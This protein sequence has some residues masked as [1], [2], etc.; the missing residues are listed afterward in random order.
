MDYLIENEDIENRLSIFNLLQKSKEQGG[1]GALQALEEFAL[2]KLFP[3]T[4]DYNIINYVNEASVLERELII[5][6]SLDAQ[7]V[8]KISYIMQRLVSICS[9]LPNGRVILTSILG[10]I[11]ERRTM[12]DDRMRY[13]V[14]KNNLKLSND[15]NASY[16]HPAIAAFLALNKLR[17]ITN[18]F[19]AV[20]AVFRCSDVI[21]KNNYCTH[22]D[23][24]KYTHI[25]TEYRPMAYPLLNK[26]GVTLKGKVTEEVLILVLAQV[27][28]ALEIAHSM[29]GYEH[30]PLELKDISY[31]DYEQNK[32]SVY[33]GNN[34]KIDSRYGAFISTINTNMEVSILNAGFLNPSTI[35]IGKES[36]VLQKRHTLRV[37]INSIPISDFG[38]EIQKRFRNIEQWNNPYEM[39]VITMHNFLSEQ[40]Y[41]LTKY[42][43]EKFEPRDLN[44]A[45][46]Q[47]LK[48]GIMEYLLLATYIESLNRS[49]IYNKIPLPKYHED[50]DKVKNIIHLLSLSLPLTLNEGN[51]ASTHL[52]YIAL[53]RALEFNAL[54]NNRKYVKDDSTALLVQS[55]LISSL[56]PVNKASKV[57]VITETKKIIT[58]FQRYTNYINMLKDIFDRDYWNIEENR[59]VKKDLTRALVPI[60]RNYQNDFD[61]GLIMTKFKFLKVYENLIKNFN[62][63]NKRDRAAQLVSAYE[64][65]SKVIDYINNIVNDINEENNI[66]NDINDENNTDENLK[67][68]IRAILD[69]SDKER[70]ANS[71]I[72]DI[73]EL[74]NMSKDMLNTKNKKEK[75]SKIYE[76]I[77]AE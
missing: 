36:I 64:A 53:N 3:S 55:R 41:V 74:I 68:L 5:N 23:N 49:I 14:L 33:V 43:P 29:Y 50:E 8:Y 58:T 21:S 25:L 40:S 27:I 73:N 30:G 76:E 67:F 34:N 39:A 45:I 71:G 15:K 12:I 70:A 20:F 54:A 51:G 35:K 2:T 24:T 62:N 57:E 18:V 66:V 75:L 56:L 42:Q 16:L 32:K 61:L 13:L 11:T 63:N 17:D 60:I 19:P 72:L 38:K 46:E 37:L 69:K 44:L 9:S 31:Y 6:K 4:L 77:N 26:D 1:E 65:S 10:P 28:G 47:N 22:I 52:R 59:E 7:S 48:R